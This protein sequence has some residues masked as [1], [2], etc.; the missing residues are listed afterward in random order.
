MEPLNHLRIPSPLEYLPIAEGKAQGI[1]VHLK[2]EDLIHP[3]IS[4][5]KWRK[6]KYNF[7]EARG[8]GLDTILTFGGAWSN[9]IHACAAAGSAFGIKTIGMIR[10]EP[11][12][13][14]NPSLAD[15]QNAG[16]HVKF[17]SRSD[18]AKKSDP[19]FI[20]QLRK[21]LGAFYL[22]PEGGANEYGI[23][24]CSE[25]VDEIASGFDFI[26]TPVG[27]GTTLVG[28]TRKL[29][30]HQKSI[31]FSSFR[32]ANH[33]VQETT[34]M[35]IISQFHFG[36]FAKI[37]GELEE[38]MLRFLSSYGILLDPVYTAKMMYG[39]LQMIS[40]GY[41]P[42]QSRIILLHTGG[43]QGLRGFPDLHR[44]L[45]AI[46]ARKGSPQAGHS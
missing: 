35:E 26:C 12:E 18:Y 10:G 2:R 14:L 1:S 41:F 7:A 11:T 13:P 9:H 15:A 19:E 31:G 4:G 27:T 46:L 8:A 39:V 37:T 17:L 25:I 38:F 44:E 3:V 23:A 22:I 6:L 16:M 24:G 21:E 42:K 20:H 34:R 29:L 40:E 5:N 30:P 33:L 28:L 45:L 43:L 36:G 32:K